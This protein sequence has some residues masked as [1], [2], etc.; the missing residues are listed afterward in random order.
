MW[1]EKYKFPFSHRER[2]RVL[3]S[4]SFAE[5]ISLYSLQLINSYHVLPACSDKRRESKEKIRI[6]KRAKCYIADCASQFR[7]VVRSEK[8][9]EL[10]AQFRL[11]RIFDNRLSGGALINFTR[12]RSQRPSSNKLIWQKA[13]ALRHVAQLLFFVAF[14][15]S[16][17]RHKS[18]D[19]P[20][21]DES[22]DCVNAKRLESSMNI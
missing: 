5:Y 21:W 9:G 8:G 14:R 10:I 7:N 16:L 11:P 15:K 1:V 2:R 6:D 13:S 18:S 3:R 22:V 20:E 19:A 4:W 17:P 12:D